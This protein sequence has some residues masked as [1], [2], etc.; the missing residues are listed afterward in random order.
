MLRID[1]PGGSALASEEILRE[2]DLFRETG[3]PLIVSMG[4]VAA[5]GGYWIAVAAE[6]IWASPATLTGSI[7]VGSAAPSFDRA[8]A[9]LGINIDGLGTTELA[10]QMDPFQG[11]GED[12]AQYLQLTVEQTYATFVT[13]IADRRALEPDEVYASAEGR[14]WIGTEALN[15]GLVDRLGELPEAIESAATLAGLEPGS[16]QVDRLEPELGWADQLLLQLARVAA[17]VLPVFGVEPVLPASVER[18][19][20]IATEPLAFL[21]QFNDPRGIYVYCFCDVD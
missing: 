12:I 10:G 2:L 9:R 3:K 13:R 20:D 16:Y 14:V 6:E 18:L 1:S 4:S 7:G 8:L 21:D 17:P 5:S 11:I 15:R 19:L